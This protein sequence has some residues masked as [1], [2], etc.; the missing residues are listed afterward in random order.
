MLYI[1]YDGIGYQT[2]SPVPTI[3]SI[4]SVRLSSAS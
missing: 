2:G 3:S 4:G 1:G